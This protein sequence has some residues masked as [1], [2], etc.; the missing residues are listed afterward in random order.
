MNSN[1]HYSIENFENK[2]YQ[3]SEDRFDLCYKQKTSILTRLQFKLKYPE[4]Y[5]HHTPSF[6]VTLY[7]NSLFIISLETNR[8]YTHEIKPSCLPIEQIPT[9][10]GYV[11]RCSKTLALH[12]DDQTYIV[13]VTFEMVE[14]SLRNVLNNFKEC[15][16]DHV[17]IDIFGCNLLGIV[18][19]F[20]VID[21]FSLDRYRWSLRSAPLKYSHWEYFKRFLR[22]WNLS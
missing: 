11:M 18:V 1:F 9:R 10:I 8:L 6:D 5:P 21:W 20:Y 13:G 15:W 17:V 16:W 2:R 3:S 19:G 4:K 14:Y 7:P 22:T 12:K